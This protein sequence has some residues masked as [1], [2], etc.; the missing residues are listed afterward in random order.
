MIIRVDLSLDRFC[1]LD[2]FALL[3]EVDFLCHIVYW[4]YRF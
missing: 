4:S 1:Y 2:R 3:S